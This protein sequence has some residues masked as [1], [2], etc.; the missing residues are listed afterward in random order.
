MKT[1]FFPRLAA[2]NIK[3]NSRTYIP[4]ILTCVMTVAMYYIVRSLSLNPGLEQMAGTDYLNGAMFLGSRVIAVFAFIFLFYTNS[5]LV[6]RRKKEFGVFHILGMEK[7]H[8]ART[9]SWESVYVTVIS[10]GA[11]FVLGIALDKLMYL[12]INCVLAAEVP[13]G[14]F[15]SWKAI[16]ETALLFALIFLLIWLHS[17]WQMKAANPVELLRGG[18]VGEREPKTRWISALA[19]AACMGSGYYIALT[20]T[21]PIASLLLFFLAVLLVI[22]GTYLLFTAGSIALLKTLR[23]NRRYYYKTRHFVSVSGMIYRMKQNAVGLANICVLST[24]VLVMVSSTTSMMVG[25]EDIIRTRYPADFM[26]YL[27]D[28]DSEGSERV[29]E[30]VHALQEEQ[31]LSVT[32][33]INYSYLAFSALQDENRFYVDRDFTMAI[34]DDINNLYFIPLSDYNRSTGEDRELKNGEVL[35]YCDRQEFDYTDLRIFDREYRVADRVDSFPGNGVYAANI[36]VTRYLVMTE[37]DFQELYLAQKQALTDIASEI[38]QVY[39]FDTDAGKEKQAHVYEALIERMTQMGASVQIES[40]EEERISSI[41]FYSGFFFIG[42]FLGLLFVMATVLIIYYKQ[43]S[44]GYDDKERF[45]IMQKVGMSREEV[46][47]SIHSQVL[48][49]FFLPLVAAGIH[50]AV[51]FPLISKLLAL[52]NL[53]NTR[54]YAVCT[55][56]CFLVFAVFYVLVY[57]LTSRS[58]SRI[59]LLSAGRRNAHNI[60]G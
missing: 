46:K 32:E 15:V 59:V 6:K 53:L 20:V 29:I 14:F 41:G 27:R 43:I 28:M 30:A 18:N 26:L 7:R 21:N 25:I 19:G 57:L 40:R 44:E 4:Y 33:E 49:V 38:L 23:K 11:G 36:T 58:Y 34:V 12:V 31:N 8:L 16:R 37:E 55:V 42:V 2:G 50:V 5:F 17:V 39:G 45:E 51:A 52:F 48:T 22:A 3:K 24:M 56:G 13:L 35:L 60:Y 9:L 54:I 10:I 1:G 47:K